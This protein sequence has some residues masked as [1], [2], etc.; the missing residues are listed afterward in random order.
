MTSDF[1]S[2]SIPLIPA[3]LD[4][5]E[6]RRCIVSDVASSYGFF[7]FFFFFFMKTFNKIT[8][9]VQNMGAT[10]TRS[11]F[12]PRLHRLNAWQGHHLRRLPM[13]LLLL[14]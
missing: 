13:L 11:P 5:V 14:Q 9:I 4:E 6:L 1:D 10:Q 8:L 7:F 12:T 3:G 2:S